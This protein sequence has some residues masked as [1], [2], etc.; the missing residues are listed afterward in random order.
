MFSGYSHT[1]GEF[2]AHGQGCLISPATG[3]VLGSVAAS[4]EDHKRDVVSSE[5]TDTGP[6][7][8]DGHVEHSQSISR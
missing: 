1:I 3:H 8:P 2:S 6:M 4:S 7:S 5:E